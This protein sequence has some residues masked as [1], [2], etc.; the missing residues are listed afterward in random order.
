[1]LAGI[2]S[3]HAGGMPQ[4][5]PS[6]DPAQDELM[7]ELSDTDLMACKKMGLDPK[8]M[9]KFKKAKAEGAAA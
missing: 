1:M 5:K 9:A 6:G 8:A 4:R 3:L 7:S 2:V